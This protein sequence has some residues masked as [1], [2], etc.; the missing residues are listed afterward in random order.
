[1]SHS[2]TNFLHDYRSNVV[3]KQLFHT[4]NS[5]SYRILI[6]FF[7]RVREKNEGAVPDRDQTSGQ[8]G[9]SI[10]S[11]CANEF[12]FVSRRSPFLFPLVFFGL[13]AH[14]FRSISHAVARSFFR[15]SNSR[16]ALSFLCTLHSLACFF[17]EFIADAKHF[18][19]VFRA[20]RCRAALWAVQRCVLIR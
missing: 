10:T 19:T 12:L 3:L 20:S 14:W 5:S 17:Y 7:L 6:F 4:R 8:Y 13:S 11:D 9:N 15:S 16:S 18:L 2:L 1:M